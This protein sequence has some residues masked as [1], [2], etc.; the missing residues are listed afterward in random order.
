MIGIAAVSEPF[1]KH[2]RLFAAA[3]NINDVSDTR[4]SYF[5]ISGKKTAAL[6]LH[7]ENAGVV[8]LFYKSMKVIF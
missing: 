1:K 7:S 8:C 4:L 3:L 2:E 5:E 6:K